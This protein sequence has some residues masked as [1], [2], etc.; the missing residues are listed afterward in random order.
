MDVDALA[1]ALDC[2]HD[3]IRPDGLTIETPFRMRRR[4]VEVKLH[5]GDGPAEVDRRLVQNIVKARCWF[6]MILAGQTFSEI[7]EAEG[8]SKRR[9]Q[10]VVDL[11]LLAPE[12]LD[13]IV[14]GEQPIWL[15]SDALIKTGFPALWT[16]Q[17]AQFAAL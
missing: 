17:R 8:T 12:V 9:V 7:A 11:A 6:R 3:Q 2:K 16:D 4:G 13:V 5:L 15:T 14:A 10:D 1:Q